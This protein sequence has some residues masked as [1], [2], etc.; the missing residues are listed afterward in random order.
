MQSNLISEFA[1]LPEFLLPDMRQFAN[2]EAKKR[3]KGKFL[4]FGK[5]KEKVDQCY[6]I[7]YPFF[8]VEYER[9]F[10]SSKGTVKKNTTTITVDACTKS[11]V[12]FRKGDFLYEFAFLSH[13]ENEEIKVLKQISPRKR[14]Y[15]KETTSIRIGSG[16]IRKI[17]TSLLS[18]GIIVVNDTRPKS[19]SVKVTLP[20]RPEIFSSLAKNRCFV[21]E[22]PKGIIVA[23]SFT[24]RDIAD[25]IQTYWEGCNIISIH[26]IRHPMYAIWYDNEE[27]GSKRIEV[28][29]GVRGKRQSYLEYV[30]SGIFENPS[31]QKT[32]GSSSTRTTNPNPTTI[33]VPVNVNSMYTGTRSGKYIEKQFFSAKSSA[34]VCSPWISKTHVEKM[35]TMSNNG[36]NIKIIT[37]NVQYNT[38]T[39]DLLRRIRST[40]NFQYKILS[41]KDFV[42]TKLYVIDRNYAVSGSTNFT[43]KGLW[44]NTE[45][46]VIFSGV[47][48]SAIIE[49]QF[50]QVWNRA[51][52][53]P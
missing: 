13:L 22:R 7:S 41:K 19:Y 26:L 25:M 17:L 34:Y 49:K 8:E 3:A 14:F 5:I 52:A 16:S 9:T 4:G 32:K 38:E 43:K 51:S 39:V 28:Y 37:Q 42:H 53:K 40:R 27:D 11:L 36:V 44:S 2:D 31:K 33:A 29:D 35:R 30:I 6:L 47:K 20:Q 23:E 18:K 50:Y 15:H 10:Q 46:I 12:N 21:K 45:S 48:E 24:A 1:I